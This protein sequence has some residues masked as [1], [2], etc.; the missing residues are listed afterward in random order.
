MPK[1]P[2]TILLF[3]FVLLTACNRGHGS[4][5]S[6]REMSA[7]EY[8]VLSAWVDARFTNGDRVGKSISKIVIFDTT[9]GDAHLQWEDNGRPIPWEK[10]AA[11]LREKDPALQQTTTDDYG[12]VNIEQAFLRQS[13]SCRFNYEVASSAQLE[14]FFKKGAGSW[15]A[16]YKQFPNSQGV[17][18]FSQVG[19]SKDRTQAMFYYSN[20]CG[21]LCGGGSYVVMNKHNGSWIIEKEIDMWVS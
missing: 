20:V 9:S 15:M 12:K 19:F 8:E 16:Y 1:T 2:L 13:L 18:T 6:K 14:P 17:L 7:A 11:S 4:A 10:Q 5:T 3:C 21:G